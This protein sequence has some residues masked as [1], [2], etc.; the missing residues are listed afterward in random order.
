VLKFC[1]FPIGYTYAYSGRVLTKNQRAEFQQSRKEE[2]KQKIN[3]KYKKSKRN[4]TKK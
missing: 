1:E 4:E 3:E 2:M